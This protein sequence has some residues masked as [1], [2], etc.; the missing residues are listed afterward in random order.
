MH[1]W[2]SEMDYALINGFPERLNAD[3]LLPSFRLDQTDG[4]FRLQPLLFIRG[5]A[6]NLPVQLVSD[7]RHISQGLG[8]GFCLSIGWADLKLQSLVGGHDCRSVCLVFG[9]SCH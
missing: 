4:E 2:I 1:L 5:D 7:P 9:G 3:C 6:I 8:G